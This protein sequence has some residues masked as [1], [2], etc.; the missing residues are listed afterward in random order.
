MY[1]VCMINL[2]M[3]RMIFFAQSPSQADVGPVT[4]VIS[5]TGL[6]EAE[7][8][9]DSTSVYGVLVHDVCC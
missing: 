3:A 5:E 9:A 4:A 6:E 8:R 1:D 2:C 7:V